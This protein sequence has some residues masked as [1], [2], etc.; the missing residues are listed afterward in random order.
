[1]HYLERVCFY[2]APQSRHYLKYAQAQTKIIARE[3]G[4]RGGLHLFPCCQISERYFPVVLLH[5]A[6]L[7]L[8]QPPGWISVTCHNDVSACIFVFSLRAL[9]SHSKKWKL[10]TVGGAGEGIWRGDLIT[11]KQIQLSPFVWIWFNQHRSVTPDGE[12]VLQSLQFC[13]MK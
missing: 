5:I 10:S 11:A 8:S 4:G 7:L 6:L 2:S 13:Q 12:T 3:G 9:K 1:M